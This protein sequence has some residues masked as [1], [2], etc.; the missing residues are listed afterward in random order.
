MTPHADAVA[1]VHSE[2]AIDLVLAELVT[3]SSV[4]P[5]DEA[6][7]ADRPGEQ[8]LAEYVV[9]WLSARGVTA[10]LQEALPGRPNVVASVAGASERAVLLETHLD[11]VEVDGMTQPFLPRVANDRLYGRG[12]ADAKASLAAFMVALA[13][14]AASSC[15]PPV[16]VVLAAVADEEHAYRGVLAFLAAAG[17][18]D[19]VGAIVGEPTSLVPGIA[20]TGCVRATVRISGVSGHSSRP[21]D[22]MNAIGLAA[23]VVQ[24]IESVQPL[25]PRH[26]LLGTGSRTVTRIASGEGPNVVPGSCELDVDRRTVPG[27]EPET[28]LDELRAELDRELPG[29]VTIDPPFT[30]DYSLDTPLDATI[31]TA[32]RSALRTAGLAAEPSGMPFGT[33]ASK[34]ARVG[35]PAVVFG[36]GDIA[37]AHTIDESVDLGEVRLAVDLVLA[38][39]AALAPGADNDSTAHDSTAHD[40]TAHENN[41]ES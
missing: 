25:A 27:E 11:T 3:I 12:S 41:E 39:I 24:R 10:A 2:T 30:V 22:A 13:R 7:C 26:P 19:F 1:S 36:P 16:T 21:A 6:P 34:I 8:A 4:T 33:D 20:H 35:I 23:T 18:T 32:L 29:R 5:R 14:L 15:P 31:V 9:D 37:D 40:G 17:D 38:T 28:V